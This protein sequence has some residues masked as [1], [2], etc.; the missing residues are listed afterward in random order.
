MTTQLAICN[1]A[2]SHLAEGRP[3]AS[4]S[5]ATASARAC[6]RFYTQ[7]RDEVLREFPWPFAL[8]TTALTVIDGETTR[9]SLD[10][11]YSYEYP[12]DCLFARDVLVGSRRPQSRPVRV[13][14]VIGF[15]P[16]IEEDEEEEIEAVPAGLVIYTDAA[17]VDATATSVALPQLEYTSSGVTEAIMASDF[18]E[19]FAYLLAFT[20]APMVTGGDPYKLGQRARAAYEWTIERARNRALQEGE[21]DAEPESEFIRARG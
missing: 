12:T 19:A 10:W 9:A 20:I 4:L 5:E 2:L 17:P 1:L 6:T 11:Q 21:P 16:A 8:R 7:V 18:A 3:I 13:P 15:T 14:F